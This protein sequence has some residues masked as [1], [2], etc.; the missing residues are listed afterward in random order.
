MHVRLEEKKNLEK[1]GQQRLLTAKCA[2]FVLVSERVLEVADIM[3]RRRTY[4]AH[5]RH[6]P[7]AGIIVQN[8]VA[9]L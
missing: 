2:G 4:S 7:T 6:D 9:I 5:N 3:H 1:G 8:H